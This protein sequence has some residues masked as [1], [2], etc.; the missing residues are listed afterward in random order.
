MTK[1]TLQASGFETMTESARIQIGQPV[2]ISTQI[3]LK[4]ATPNERSLGDISIKIGEFKSI[5]L[6]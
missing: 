5:T 3:L 1:L 6:V 4:P 2:T